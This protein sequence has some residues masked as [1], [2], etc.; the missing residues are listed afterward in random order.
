MATVAANA[1]DQIMLLAAALLV[2]LSLSIPPP[3]SPVS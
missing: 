2:L 3:L 1:K